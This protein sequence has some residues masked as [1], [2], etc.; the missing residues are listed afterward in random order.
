M[1]G[2]AGGRSAGP[3]GAGRTGGSGGGEA[4]GEAGAAAEGLN[5]GSALLHVLSDSLR[6]A[7]TLVEV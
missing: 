7:T 1:G 3:G 4:M 5:M 2:T 6:S